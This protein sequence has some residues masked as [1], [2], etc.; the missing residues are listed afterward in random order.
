MNTLKTDDIYATFHY[1]N[2]MK[3]IGIF[4]SGCGGLSLVNALQYRQESFDIVYYAD[5]KWFPWGNK[6]RDVLLPRLHEISSV[7]TVRNACRQFSQRAKEEQ[8]R[9]E[10]RHK[11]RADTS[12]TNSAGD[13]PSKQRNT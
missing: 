13:A 4:D 5:T 12:T 6:S 2:C 10:H 8:R 1:G 9:E 11:Q 3:K 7:F